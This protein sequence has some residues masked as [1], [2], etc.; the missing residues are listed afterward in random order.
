MTT[1]PLIDER[2][3][4][5]KRNTMIAMAFAAVVCIVAVVLAANSLSS[6]GEGSETPFGELGSAPGAGATPPPSGSGSPTAPAEPAPLTAFS[7]PS[8]NIGCVI[9]TEVARCDIAERD[10]EPGAPPATCKKT[11][12][13]GTAV[14]A[15]EAAITCTRGSVL[16]SKTVLGYGR[17][18]TEGTFTC[19]SSEAGMRC[20]NTATGRG[21]SIS[22]KTYTFF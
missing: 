9:S 16:G 6:I 14:G 13:Q 7:S 1:T 2:E 20:E 19:A 17:S 4:M 3:H 21:F 22:R 10:W 18:V 5:K 15:K 8:G 12:G 11:W